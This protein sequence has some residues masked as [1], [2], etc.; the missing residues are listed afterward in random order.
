MPIWW[1][2]QPYHLRV[3]YSQ[4]IQVLQTQKILA[5]PPTPAASAM[6]SAAPRIKPKLRP[7]RTIACPQQDV[8]LQLQ[9]DATQAPKL[10][11]ATL[12]KTMCELLEDKID[13]LKIVLVFVPPK[14]Y[15]SDTIKVWKKVWSFFMAKKLVN[16]ITQDH[17]KE[18]FRAF[19]IQPWLSSSSTASP[20]HSTCH[21]FLKIEERTNPYHLR[22]GWL[23]ETCAIP[24]HFLDWGH[25]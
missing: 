14:H 5:E 10:M 8:I 11:A 21:I 4:N 15:Q 3:F 20:W 25:I 16:L 7:S 2:I 24:S 19:S 17:N 23:G 22:R 9:V 6:P 13:D 18:Y 1:A 12:N